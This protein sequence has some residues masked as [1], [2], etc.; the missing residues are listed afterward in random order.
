MID[1]K[2]YRKAL[3][4]FERYD[5]VRYFT[6]RRYYPT[7]LW[8]EDAE[9]STKCGLWKAAVTYNPEMDCTFTHY[10]ISCIMAEMTVSTRIINKHKAASDKAIKCASKNIPQNSVEDETC[11]DLLDFIDHLPDELREV[12]KLKMAGYNRYEIAEMIHITFRS[13]NRRLKK[14]LGMWKELNRE[15]D[16]A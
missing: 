7:L 5:K 16:A 1:E 9:Q 3:Q 15:I 4:L 13:V 14:A 11:F 2:Q 10:A 6:L 12:V 8:D